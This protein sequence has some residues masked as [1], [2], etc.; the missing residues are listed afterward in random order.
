MALINEHF[1]KLKGTY[2]FDD[3]AKKINAFKISHP[4]IKLIDLATGDVSQPLCP[5]VIEAMHKAVDEMGRKDTFKGYGPGQGYK[6]LR[7]AIVK[8]DY[9][10]HGV[11]IDISEVFVNDGAKSDT[12]NIQELI[13]WDNSIGVTDPVYP[14]YIESNAMIGRAGKHD[15]GMW[16]NVVY[17]PCTAD[18]EYLPQ[19]PSQ[20][21]DVIY[22]CNP[23][24]PMGTVM[25][26]EVLKKWVNF[27]IKND[28]LIFYDAAYAAY[29]QDDDVPHSIYEIKGARHVAIEFRSYSKTAGFTGLRCGYTIVPKALTA[30]TFDSGE[31]I[32]LN[33]LWHRRQ[34]A[35]F[36]GVSYVTQRAAEATYSEEGLRQV[37]ET[38][39]YYMDTANIMRDMFIK[40]GWNVVGGQNAPYLW[41]KVPDSDDSSHFFMQLLYNLGVACM[42][43]SGFGPSGEGYF[44]LTS[45]AQRED[46]IEGVRRILSNYANG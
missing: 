12:G 9:Q 30:V 18:N 46:C 26:R 7:E 27:A 3:I 32:S 22:L 41:L 15:N 11:N 19:L 17:I 10:L 14:V 45:L 35:K 40:S 13:R 16:T 33:A 8:H 24:N 5:A 43:G 20:P 38:V 1:L 39:R 4:K 34:S 6:F 29:I 25:T 42:P 44:R 23:N 37:K 36:N 21:V 2:F 31:R 28:V